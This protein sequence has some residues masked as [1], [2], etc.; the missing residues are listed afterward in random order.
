MTD[1][2]RATGGTTAGFEPQRFARALRRLTLPFAV[3]AGIVFWQMYGVI[4]VPEGMDTIPSI[5]PGSTCLV[6]KSGS[7]AMVGHEVFC[8]VPDGGTVLSRVTEITADGRLVLRHD[9][10][11]SRLPD[12]RAFGPVSRESVRGVVLV[13]FGSDVA[14]EVP[15]G[16]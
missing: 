12:S 3:I 4:R 2:M 8:D 14:A 13:V 1:S 16:K 5:A 10:V 15:R 11:E 7:K 6:A 9:H